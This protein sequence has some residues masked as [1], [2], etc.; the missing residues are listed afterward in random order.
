MKLA[1]EHRTKS[2][3]G[4]N[5][6]YIQVTAKK[7]IKFMSGGYST[8]EKLK[9]SSSYKYAVK[10]KKHLDYLAEKGCDFVPKCYQII[11]C[12]IGMNYFVGIVLQHLGNRLLRDMNRVD[13]YDIMK[14]LR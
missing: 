7:G 8:K 13:T 9:E 14:N 1:S 11:M 10:E 6:F 3:S 2:P 12:K 4:C 5:G